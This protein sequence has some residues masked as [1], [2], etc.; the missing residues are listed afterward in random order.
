MKLILASNSPRRRE[1]L[2]QICEQF[3][4][5]PSLYDE[6]AR[7]LSA[8]ET[9]LL[10]ARGKAEEVFGRF[11]GAAVL[12][13]DTVV[14]LGGRVLGKP[15]N[16]SCASEMLHFLSG[17]THSVFTG[18]CLVT[19]NGED[20]FYTETKVTFNELSDELIG[21]YIESVRPFDR[22][23]AYGIQDGFPLVKSY[24]GSYTGIMGLPVEETRSLLL[25]RNLI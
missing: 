21:E 23:G 9:V 22:A 25:G 2:A 15:G 4:V 12:G 3:T 17:K 20:R 7:G 19:E 5:V 14:A 6:A 24:A 1:L 10:F 8:C 18:V 11:P 13:A 16:A